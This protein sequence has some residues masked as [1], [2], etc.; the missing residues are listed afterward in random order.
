KFHFTTELSIRISDVNYANHLGNDAVLSLIHE[1]RIR[2]LK[3]LGYSEMDVEGVGIMVA[4]ALIIYK[5]QGFHGDTLVVDI[6]VEEPFRV[7]CVLY[8]RL[9]NKESGK[10]VARCRTAIVFFNFQT[11]ELA[12]I[13]SAFLKALKEL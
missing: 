1:A 9:S 3:S 12:R 10:E 4:D 13:P 2:F 11:Q 5:S 8:Y 6:A 7:G